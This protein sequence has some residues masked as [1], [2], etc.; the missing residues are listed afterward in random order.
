MTGAGHPKIHLTSAELGTWT[1]IY[2]HS[3]S[4]RP[5]PTNFQDLGPSVQSLSNQFIN[6]IHFPTDSLPSHHPSIIYVALQLD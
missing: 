6:Y 5:Y 1:S 2:T 4:E 3:C